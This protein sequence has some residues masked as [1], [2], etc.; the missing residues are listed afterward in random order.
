MTLLKLTRP[1]EVGEH[2]SKAR[3]VSIKLFSCKRTIEITTLGEHDSVRISQQPTANL[4]QKS[5]CLTQSL[6]GHQA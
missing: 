3:L 6:K 4:S 5:S 1:H 2:Y